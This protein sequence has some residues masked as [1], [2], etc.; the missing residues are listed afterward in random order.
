M[1]FQKL[2]NRVALL[3]HVRSAWALNSVVH[4]NSDNARLLAKIIDPHKR[5]EQTNT[6]LIENKA[7]L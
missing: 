2:K 7:S 5:P 3:N 1:Y 4:L 6:G